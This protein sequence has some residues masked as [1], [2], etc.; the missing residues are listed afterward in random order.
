[1]LARYY[2]TPYK[3]LGDAS[4]IESTPH[5]TLVRKNVGENMTI[6]V[7]HQSL[8][9]DVRKNSNLLYH[10]VHSLGVLV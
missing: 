9:Y 7:S 3:P 6:A 5:E 8:Q 2:S 10:G 1:M 4:E